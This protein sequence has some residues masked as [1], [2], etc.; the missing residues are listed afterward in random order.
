MV[1]AVR[2]RAPPSDSAGVQSNRVVVRTQAYV[3]KAQ[4]GSGPPVHHGPHQRARLDRTMTCCSCSS[5]TPCSL[6]RSGS[7][8]VL[9]CHGTAPAGDHLL[10]PVPV[11]S[12]EVS[13]Y[14]AAWPAIDAFCR[15]RFSMRQPSREATVPETLI[16]DYEVTMATPEC[17]PGSNRL[18][19]CVRSVSYTHL[20]AHET[21]ANL[22]CS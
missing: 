1:S 18:R 16:R 12:G 13:V 2:F 17:N 11:D 6:S 19:A 10:G 8:R 4:G 15:S 21:K 22:V 9:R 14:S 5:V 3:Q 20:R 7:Q